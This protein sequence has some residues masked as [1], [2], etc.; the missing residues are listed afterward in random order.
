MVL[1]VVTVIRWN[2]M[3]ADGRIEKRNGSQNMSQRFRNRKILD[4]PLFIVI[5][6]KEL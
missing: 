3:E 5:S 6:F 4:Q 1:L 2:K